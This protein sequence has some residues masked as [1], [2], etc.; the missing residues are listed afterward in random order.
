MGCAA[1][2]APT[3]VS[4][5]RRRACRGSGRKVLTPGSCEGFA[6]PP[7]PRAGSVRNVVPAGTAVRLRLWFCC[8]ALDLL[9]GTAERQPKLAEGR[10][11]SAVALMWPRRAGPRRT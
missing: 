11:A 9:G 2:W 5:L 3:A 1:R 7:A 10:A 8:P 6:F 4:A